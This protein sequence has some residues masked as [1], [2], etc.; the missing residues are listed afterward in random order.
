[1][2]RVV[3]KKSAYFSYSPR[4]ELCDSRVVSLRWFGLILLP[5]VSFAAD[6]TVAI[7]YFVQNTVLHLLG[8]KAMVPSLLARA[9][10]IDLSI[11]FTLWWMPFLVLLGWMMNRPMMLLFDFFELALLLG[12]CFLVNYITADAK[13]NWVEGLILVSFYAMIVSVL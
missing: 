2:K 11:Q 8:K 3:S 7:V 12:S 9:R 1:M 5:I 4:Y 13:T 6:G 10:A